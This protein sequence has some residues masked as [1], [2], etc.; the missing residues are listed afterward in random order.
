MKVSLN[1]IYIKIILIALLLFVCIT[2]FIYI[3]RHKYSYT[4]EG[5]E[6]DAEQEDSESSESQDT[7]SWSYPSEVSNIINAFK[8]DFGV[9]LI[10]GISTSLTSTNP[11]E[12]ILNINGSIYTLTLPAINNEAIMAH[13]IDKYYE[14]NKTLCDGII[15]YYQ[16]LFQKNVESIHGNIS[17]SFQSFISYMKQ[18]FEKTDMFRKYQDVGTEIQRLKTS[19]SKTN[20]E[21]SAYNDYNT[22]ENQFK[23]TYV[24]NNFNN[25]GV[26][27]IDYNEKQYFKD[28]E[29]KNIYK[30]DQTNN[31]RRLFIVIKNRI[32]ITAVT[33]AIRTRNFKLKVCAKLR[34]FE[35]C[36]K[37]LHVILFYIIA[38]QLNT[39][40]QYDYDIIK[41]EMR[42]CA[43]YFTPYG[44][45]CDLY[46]ELFKLSNMQLK[47]LIN[48][49]LQNRG[50]KSYLI[51]FLDPDKSPI[52]INIYS[53]EIMNI[54][55]NIAKN[56]IINPKTLEPYVDSIAYRQLY[57]LFRSLDSFKSTKINDAKLNLGIKNLLTLYYDVSIKQL[58]QEFLLTKHKDISTV[59]QNRIRYNGKIY[60][61]STLQTIFA[62]KN[63]D[64]DN[65]IQI[66][67]IDFTNFGLRELKKSLHNN[68]DY[69]YKV[70]NNNFN[71]NNVYNDN[72]HLSGACFY[73]LSQDEVN[74]E[75]CRERKIQEITSTYQSRKPCNNVLTNITCTSGCD[76]SPGKLKNKFLAFDMQVAGNI[77]AV[78][79]LNSSISISG[80][81]PL[82][83]KIKIINNINDYKYSIKFCKFNNID[84]RFVEYTVSELNSKKSEIKGIIKRIFYQI[85]FQSNSVKFSTRDVSIPVYVCNFYNNILYEYQVINTNIN[86]AD[87]GFINDVPLSSNGNIFDKLLNNNIL[88]DA[89]KSSKNRTCHLT[90]A[91]DCELIKNVNIQSICNIEDY[92][93]Q[94]RCLNDKLYTAK[95]IRENYYKQWQAYHQSNIDILSNEIKNLE[96]AN[97]ELESQINSLT[98][99]PTKDAINNNIYNLIDQLLVII[100]PN[101][102]FWRKTILDILFNK[103]YPIPISLDNYKD[104]F[105]NI[106]SSSWTTPI[107]LQRIYICQKEGQQNCRS[108]V[109][110]VN[111]AEFLQGINTIKEIVD[112]SVNK[113]NRD[114]GSSSE[115]YKCADEDQKCF[116]SYCFSSFGCEVNYGIGDKWNVHDLN[117][118]SRQFNQYNEYNEKRSYFYCNNDNMGDPAVWQRKICYVRKAKSYSEKQFHIF[119]SN[120]QEGINSIHKGAQPINAHIINRKALDS[121]LL[122]KSG[123]ETLLTSKRSEKS[124]HETNLKIYTVNFSNINKKDTSEYIG[125]DIENYVP[126]KS[127]LNDSEQNTLATIFQLNNITTNTITYNK[128]IANLVYVSQ[129]FDNKFIHSND[130]SIYIRLR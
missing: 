98:G 122:T 30:G 114:Y 97:R 41:A 5:F 24:Y 44:A 45:E 55:N 28:L 101:E 70:Y 115:F 62:K 79:K 110:D 22:A 47:I 92:E 1:T 78:E 76:D 25:C 91:N 89:E 120:L 18:K 32:I 86:L 37:I 121:A 8:E 65:P 109:N 75:S 15:I 106:V 51:N 128:Y 54:L 105:E 74:S 58:Y 67:K 49:I 127:I 80:D 23:I 31:A 33:D 10:V 102:N 20:K 126:L 84:K 107:I 117:K 81:N 130:N 103:P 83:L 72:V 123:N 2:T 19:S 35:L 9:D 99:T 59:T 42:G 119:F 90:S 56:D 108:I 4:E 60:E 14:T 125:T 63:A 100:K 64:P 21:T 48:K 17:K 46:P 85:K 73:A 7:I 34:I 61:L 43:M 29:N 53:F 13:I 52:Y 39:C 68:Y 116:D 3:Y 96:D 95:R 113:Y 38:Y 40:F 50:S 66:C 124:E 26:K 87:F 118:D 27:N 111:F 12:I 16:E 93:E 88:E 82:F 57:N 94:K 77:K 11:N 71:P 129:S 112:L 6:I 36:I 69:P 104:F